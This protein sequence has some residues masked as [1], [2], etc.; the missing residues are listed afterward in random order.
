MQSSVRTI[1]FPVAGPRRFSEDDATA[2][3]SELRPI[4][5][6]PVIRFAIEEARRAGVTR[7]IFITSTEKSLLERQIQEICNKVRSDEAAQYGSAPPMEVLFIRQAHRKGI[8]H[9][10]LI[11]RERLAGEPF[12]V[13]IPNLLIIG[14][15]AGLRNMVQGYERGTV[16]IGYTER[17]RDKLNNFGV[18]ELEPDSAS[19]VRTVH[20]KPSHYDELSGAAAF[21]R[22]ICDD[23]V[24]DRLAETPANGSG[25]I[26]LTEAI[27][28]LAGEA[29]VRAIP[30]GGLCFD[31]RQPDGFVQATIARA[32]QRPELSD[33]IVDAQRSFLAGVST[34]RSAAWTQRY[35]ELT[36]LAL[37]SQLIE[38]DFKGG[39]AL[40]SSFGAD[41]AVLLHLLSRVSR[42]TPV[43]F[44]ETGKLF[45]ETLAY[46]R[47][48]AEQLGLKQ[49][50]F[51]RPDATSL[52]T[53]DPEGELHKT[54]PDA[55]CNV[56]KSLP[57]KVALG[58]FDAWITGRRRTQST[59]RAGLELF[60]EDE[61][62]RLKANPLQGWTRA[63][64]AEYFALHALP[65][66]PLKARGYPSIGC[67]PCTTP[68]AAGEDERAGRWRG[69]DK[70][71]C[72]IH[73]ENGKIVR[74]AGQP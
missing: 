53:I 36:P 17:P 41:S 49:V 67:T 14:E 62:G 25:E 30:V 27:N 60:E 7:L 20:E 12:A 55:C 45:P 59:S 48:L 34:L 6:M 35:K 65:E 11:S 22:W 70:I 63:D 8:G 54:N 5:D 3:F 71:E 39:I 47:T 32:M 64:V 43:F 28:A 19:L 58:P 24:L 37:L 74:A 2:N 4:V 51:V 26:S 66:H 18:L 68:V 52:R 46:Q 73:I 10:L 72:G 21:G 15:G 16:L 9:A 31:L 61:D 1:V 13:M 38:K 50:R 40:V 69:R 44:I 23:A 56:R 42:D 57:L 29:R 33:A